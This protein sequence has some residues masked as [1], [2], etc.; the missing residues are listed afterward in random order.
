VK[1]KQLFLLFAKGEAVTWTLLISALIIRAAGDPIPHIVTIAGSIHGA[2][3]LG[4]AVTA[5]LVGI[6]QRWSFGKL[7]LAVGL[8]IV[9]FATIPFE[10]KLTRS[11]ALEGTWRTAKSEDPRDDFFIDAIFRWFIARPIVLLAVLLVAVP[12]V[13]AFL[14]F[15]GPPTQW[16]D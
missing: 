4:Y 15:L 8:A 2:V 1:P 5:L 9:P 10:R 6:N 7:A 12:A 13:F 3:F 16:F 11:S 14:L